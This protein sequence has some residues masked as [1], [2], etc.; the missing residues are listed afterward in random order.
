[1]ASIG[2]LDA[3]YVEPEARGVGV[4][5]ALLDDLVRWFESTG[6][7]GVDAA[8]LPGDRDTKN[9]FEAAG[10]KARLITMHRALG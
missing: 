10:F 6:C 7:R 5:R 1:E 3:C 8:A 2:A 4:G 9:F